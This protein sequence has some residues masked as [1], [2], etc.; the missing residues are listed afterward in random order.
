MRKQITAARDFPFERRTQRIGVNC[1][2]QQIALPR[3]VF[4]RRFGELLPTGHST[5][6]LYVNF[7]GD[8]GQ[9]R[10]RSAYLGN[11]E[12]LA[13]AKRRYDPD[14]TFHVNQNVRPAE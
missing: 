4:H 12:R 7:L 6:H 5:M 10:V 8:D 14:N 2:E 9:Q 13:R 11:H 1:N 3:K